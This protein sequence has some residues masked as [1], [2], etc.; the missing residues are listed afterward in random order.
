[1]KTSLTIPLFCLDD[2]DTH[3]E[4]N[5]IY[6]YMPTVMYLCKGSTYLIF[7]YSGLRLDI[8]HYSVGENITIA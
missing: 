4:G 6:L 7:V 8:F 1:M 3:K 2:T 5:N